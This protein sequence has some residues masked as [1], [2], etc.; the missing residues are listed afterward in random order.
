MGSRG[1]SGIGKYAERFA[2]GTPEQLKVAETNLNGY[3]K[4]LTK[5]VNEQKTALKAGV[6]VAEQLET[7]SRSLRE[8]KLQ[9]KELDRELKRR[10]AASERSLED[11]ITEIVRKLDTNDYKSASERTKL[12]REYA[13]LNN[14]RSVANLRRFNNRNG[15]R[16]EWQ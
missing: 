8:V 2:D 10:E 12:E 3:I 14:Q 11:R 16:K 5:T 15:V 13:R 7:N 1:A 4:H 6:D 9:K